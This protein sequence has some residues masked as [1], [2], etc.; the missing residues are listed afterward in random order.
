M[1]ENE[2]DRVISTPHWYSDTPGRPLHSGGYRPDPKAAGAEA[3][4]DLY[5]LA[6]CDHLIVDTSS[7][8]AYVATLLA[9]SSTRVVDTK[10]RDKLPPRLR[11][12][13][14]VL[15]NRSRFH[16]WAPSLIGRLA[17]YNRYV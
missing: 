8:F 6:E 15:M 3:L 12:M 7:S 14:T 13:S 1:F 10:R 16:S 11:R 4:I 5:L 17:R 2:F 9:E